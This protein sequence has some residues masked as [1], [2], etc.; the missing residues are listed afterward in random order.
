MRNPFRCFNSSPEVIR[1]TVMMYIRYPLS[2]R[3]VEDLLFERGIDI[4]HETVRF[5]WNRFGPIFAAE[6]RKRRI[7]HRSYSRWRWH[8]DE[9]FVRINGKMHYLW[10][11]VD[12]EGEVLEVFATKRRDRKAAL[13]VSEARDEALRQA[14]GH[15]D[16]P[17]ALL[18][19]CDERDRRRSNARF[20]VAGSTI[21]PKIHI[22]R[23]DDER[24]QWPNSGTYKTLQKFASVHASLFNHFN[25]DRHLNRRDVFKQS[26]AAALAE[27]R[28]LAA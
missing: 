22:S 13:S 15:R 9:V 25:T 11:A 28:E 10:R 27:W 26:R 24:V 7:Q 23:S 16:R 19:R 4:C 5:W 8:L 6:I 1:L 21:E 20:A 17:A 18:R 14:T 3:Q 2:L 12:H